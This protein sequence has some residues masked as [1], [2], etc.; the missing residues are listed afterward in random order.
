MYTKVRQYIEQRNAQAKAMNHSDHAHD[1]PHDPAH[2]ETTAPTPGATPSS[3]EAHTDAAHP[4]AHPTGAHPASEGT[5]YDLSVE[6]ILG[7]GLLGKAFIGLK[8]FF[9]KKLREIAGGTTVSVKN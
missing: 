8:N 6:N 5:F 1:T 2:P 7:H 4:A 3:A 9:P